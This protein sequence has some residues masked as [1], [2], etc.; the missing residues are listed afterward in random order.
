MSSYSNTP[1]ARVQGLQCCQQCNDHTCSMH[2]TKIFHLWI[3]FFFFLMF[4]VFGCAYTVQ[5][6]RNTESTLGNW[7]AVDLPATTISPKSRSARC[8]HAPVGS[9][10]KMN[11]HS[12]HDRWLLASGDVFF[13]SFFLLLLLFFFK[14]T[15]HTHAP[16][17][18]GKTPSNN[19]SLK[20]FINLEVHAKNAP[21]GE[22]MHAHE[23]NTER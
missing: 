7:K 13:V 2:G 3:S 23:R 6:T 12:T 10:S 4:V 16:I 5:C 9:S 14:E 22:H 19:W 1:P 17:W 21:N 11:A 15:K 8:P 18:D 20:M